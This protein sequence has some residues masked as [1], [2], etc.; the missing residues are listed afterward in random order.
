MSW[1]NKLLM[2]GSYENQNRITNLKTV[3]YNTPWITAVALA[4]SLTS[5]NVMAETTAGGL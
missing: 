5:T 4:T 3:K 2:M 1:S